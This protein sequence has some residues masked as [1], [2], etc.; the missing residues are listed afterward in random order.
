M[1]RKL[2]K[3][4]TMRLKKE[5]MVWMT[6]MWCWHDEQVVKAKKVFVVGPL[7]LLWMLTQGLGL[8]SCFSRKAAFHG[9]GPRR[10]LARKGKLRRLACAED[11]PGSATEQGFVVGYVVRREDGRIR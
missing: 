7:K 10:E 3:M 8:A 9:H 1:S 11:G 6:T 2:G 5:L 4:A